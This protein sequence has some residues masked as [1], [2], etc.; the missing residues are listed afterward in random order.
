M[1][2]WTFGT[3]THH[4][5]QPETGDARNCLPPCWGRHRDAPVALYASNLIALTND[6]TGGCARGQWAAVQSLKHRLV[7]K[8]P[9]IP[10]R[11]FVNRCWRGRRLGLLCQPACSSELS[12]QLQ[13]FTI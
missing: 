12:R 2:A 7:W 8:H 3:Y 11:P 9:G 4:D 10:Q 5:R 6:D 13:R 1:K